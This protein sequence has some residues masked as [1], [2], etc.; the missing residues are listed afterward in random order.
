VLFLE[1]ETGKVS[2]V[3]IPMVLIYQ[4]TCSHWVMP[5][6]LEII[7]L[8]FCFNSSHV[9]AIWSPF[10]HILIFSFRH[11][12]YHTRVLV[13]LLLH[14]DL[15]LAFPL[16]GSASFDFVF[17]PISNFEFVVFLSFS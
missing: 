9:H 16:A 8:L 2:C 14:F 1:D 4:C 7:A 17:R 3:A 5:A 12:P 13:L 15:L 6:G 11:L 10:N